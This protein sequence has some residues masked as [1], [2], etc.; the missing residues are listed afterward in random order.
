VEH[1]G[2]IAEAASLAAIDLPRSSYPLWDS[3]PTDLVEGGGLSALQL[4]GVM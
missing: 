1:P 3:L 4:E 2:D